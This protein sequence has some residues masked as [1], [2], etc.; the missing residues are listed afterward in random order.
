[1]FQIEMR[2]DGRWTVLGG[3]Y[4]YQEADRKIM[5]YRECSPQQRQREYRV[6]PV[7]GMT[8]TAVPAVA[9]IESRISRFKNM[10]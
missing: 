7:G 3:S 5:Q 9:K 2:V 8:K 4:T 1:M 10:R 6:V